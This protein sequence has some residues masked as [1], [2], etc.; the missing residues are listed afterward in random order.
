MG[1]HLAWPRLGT[2]VRVL[3]ATALGTLWAVPAGLA[4]G[5]SPRLSPHHP[6]G[7]AGRRVVPRADALSRRDRRARGRWH[8]AR[9]GQHR[10]HA[11]R[12]PVVHPLQRHRRRQRHSRRSAGMTTQLS[13]FRLA[14]LS[15]SLLP[16][17]LPVSRH[18]LGH[19]R[20]RRLERQHRLRVRTRAATTTSA[21]LGPRRR[22]QLRRR[23]HRLPHAGRQRA[24]HVHAW[25]CSSTGRS[26]GAA[27]AWRKNATP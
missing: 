7:R 8:R 10:A 9:L 13:H 22:D 1:R 16:G 24:R 21:N 27:T 2:L 6:A 20:R 3:A 11:A 15:R 18:R 17:R 25:S 5:L 19:G 12:H 14:A 23:A 4:I 26:G